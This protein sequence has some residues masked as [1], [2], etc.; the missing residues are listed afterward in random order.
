M[1]ELPLQ[2]TGTKRHA[3][4]MLLKRSVAL[5]A[6]RHSMASALAELVLSG[7][8]R[9]HANSVKKELL[10]DPASLILHPPKHRVPNDAPQKLLSRKSAQSSPALFITRDHSGQSVQQTK[11]LFDFFSSPLAPPSDKSCKP[12]SSMGKVEARVVW[13]EQQNLRQLHAHHVI[14]F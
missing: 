1:S 7:P 9:R 4:Q 8:C 5:A 2:R 14:F 11:N 6:R 10:L 3:S 13:Q 12:F